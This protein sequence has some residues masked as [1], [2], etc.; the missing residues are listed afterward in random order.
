MPENQYSTPDESKQ[1]Y[2]RR[3]PIPDLTPIE[4]E[5][6]WAKVDK[7]G[8]DSDGAY[9]EYQ[10][11]PCWIWTAAHHPDGYGLFTASGKQLR[12]SR[13]SYKQRYGVDPDQLDICHYCHYPPCI[14]PDHTR[15]DTRHG[16]MQE[17]AQAGRIHNQ[18]PFRFFTNDEI[19]EVRTAASN[20]ESAVDIAIRYQGATDGQ[21]DKIARGK[22][23][24]HIGGPIVLSNPD[25]RHQDN[26]HEAIL[27]VADI[28]YIWKACLDDRVPKTEIGD[29]FGV[30]SAAIRSILRGRTWIEASAA[31]LATKNLTLA[32]GI[33]L[34]YSTRALSRRRHR[35][36]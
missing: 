2:S 16:N 6:F 34:A 19:V 1:L 31:F 7:S 22:T 30:S 11:T 29:C 33:A 35:L 24:K 8:Y 9:H 15:R 14:N 20:G 18:A 3:T 32:E 4:H 27:T 23:H 28:P 36:Y 21:I 26:N 17:A 13:I 5:R 10:G 25:W 12:A